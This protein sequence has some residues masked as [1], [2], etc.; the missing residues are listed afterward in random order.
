MSKK[1]TISLPDYVARIA[2]IKAKL[3]FGGNFSNY[4][5]YLI[6]SDNADD[7]KKLLEDEENQK[8]KQISE[9]RPAEFSNRC[10]CCN[11]KIKIGEKIC[12][13]LFNDGHEQ[14]VHKKCCKV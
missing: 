5:Q 7:I 12:N 2:E 4:L 13:A 8:P 1:K 3:K 9:A 11:K 10:P 6:C 14:F